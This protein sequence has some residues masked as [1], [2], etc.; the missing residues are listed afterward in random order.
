MADDGANRLQPKLLCLRALPSFP[1]ATWECDL[2]RVAVCANSPATRARYEFPSGAWELATGL[3]DLPGLARGVNGY[4]T[5]CYWRMPSMDKYIS[6][7]C[8]AGPKSR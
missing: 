6:T 2:D 5:W 4:I 1:S 8:D 7:A 3:E